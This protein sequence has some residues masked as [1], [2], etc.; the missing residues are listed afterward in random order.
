MKDC[1]QSPACDFRA[2]IAAVQRIVIKIGT[3]VLMRDDGAAAVGLI[4]GLVESI[5]NVRKQGREVLLVSSG[6]IGMGKNTLQITANGLDLPLKQACAAVGQIRLMSLY[7]D[8]FRHLGMHAA[9]VLLTEDDFLDPVRYE[10]LQATL[11]TLLRLGVVPIINENDTVS[12]L[13]IDRPSNAEGTANVFGD[14]DKLSAL[15]A[16]EVNAGLLVLLSDVDG[17]YTRHPDD[18]QAR[19]IP[20]V[21]KVTGEVLSWAKHSEGRGR[22]GMLSKIRAAEMAA[23]SGR[24]VVIGNGRVGS[25]MDRICAGEEVGT[26]FL[27]GKPE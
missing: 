27:P 23:N 3:N 11:S 20:T 9:Q 7:V 5:V 24:I 14:N 2:R 18:P 19:F 8:A 12:T 15:V 22:G 6:A 17:L 13:E 21:E 1:D 16:R 26:M 10:N 25:I 4:Y